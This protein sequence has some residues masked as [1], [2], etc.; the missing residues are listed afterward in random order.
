MKTFLAITATAMLASSASAGLTTDTFSYANSAA[1]EAVYT[2]SNTSGGDWNATFDGSKFTVNGSTPATG[3]F[4]SFYA[5]R[6]IGS[7][8]GNFSVTIDAT[9]LSANES[10]ERARIAVEVLK[11]DGSGSHPT[12]LTPTQPWTAPNTVASAGIWNDYGINA[13]STMIAG[14]DNPAIVPSNFPWQ[15]Q[16]AIGTGGNATLTVKRVA[17]ILTV[18]YNGGSVSRSYS[19]PNSDTITY[20]GLWYSHFTGYPGVYDGSAT[21]TLDNL[22]VYTPPAGLQPGDANRDG[23][24]DIN[25]YLLIRGHAFVAAPYGP[26]PLGDLNDDEFVDFN[27]FQ[28]WKTAFPGGAVAAEAAI[29]ALIPEPS[30]VSI[31]LCGLA[32]LLWRARRRTPR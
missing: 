25:D 20:V 23:S 27:D 22:N 10:G 11:G 19:L 29:A 17:G 26:T 14:H 7:I 32:A 8:T 18:A 30:S 4:D 1:F 2:K 5:I 16:I 9:W 6:P 3:N 24:V 21:Y 13:T 12:G 31:S 28:I 15:P